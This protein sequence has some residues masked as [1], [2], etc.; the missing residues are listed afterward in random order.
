MYYEPIRFPL[1]IKAVA[2]STSA[3]LN[4]NGI[5]PGQSDESVSNALD[6]LT[7]SHAYNLG[8]VNH[9]YGLKVLYSTNKDEASV[10]TDFSASNSHRNSTTATAHTTANTTGAL[11]DASAAS[12]AKIHFDRAGRM[13]A[14][15]L[16]MERSRSKDD[17]HHRNNVH[18]LIVVLGCLN[19]LADLYHKS[20]QGVR[21][22]HCYMQLKTTS[23][24]MLGLLLRGQPSPHHQRE[25][26][27]LRS[28][29]PS[30]WTRARKGLSRWRRRSNSSG[31][32][33]SEN[34][35]PVEQNT[36]AR[37]TRTSPWAS[38]S[39]YVFNSPS[40]GAA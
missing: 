40:A 17:P 22:K 6:L 39:Q 31:E 5:D 27:L 32:I 38:Q 35:D 4:D 33:M 12:R 18:R 1:A 13:Y 16:R 14:L 26:R 28:Y 34:E 23:E 20:H 11:D 25:E 3:I 19:N 36:S 29:L 7:T 9:I 37:S 24:Q 10:R 21:S 2:S 30:F 15:V 8:L